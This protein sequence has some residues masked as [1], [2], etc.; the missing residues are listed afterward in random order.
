MIRESIP[1]QFEGLNVWS[2]GD[3]RPHSNLEQAA[4]VPA[5]SRQADGVKFLTPS[6]GAAFRRRTAE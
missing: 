6:A 1:R 4:R 2:V 3:Q 5:F